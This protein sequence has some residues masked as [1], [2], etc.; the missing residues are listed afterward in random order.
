MRIVRHV[1]LYAG[2]IA[3]DLL[4]R[5]RQLSIAA[6]CDEDV[7]SFVHELLRARQADAAI[8]AGNERNLSFELAHG[9]ISSR[10]SSD[11]HNLSAALPLGR[12]FC[13]TG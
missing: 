6:P 13:P 4:D 8:A 10:F 9:G 5:G 11:L 3:S 7:G 2:D 12:Y 1:S